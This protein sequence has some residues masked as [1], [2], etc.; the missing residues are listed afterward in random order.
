MKRLELLSKVDMPALQGNLLK[1]RQRALVRNDLPKSA[2][3]AARIFGA[4][5]QGNFGSESQRQPK[6]ASGRH[7]PRSGRHSER[8]LESKEVASVSRSG[9]SVKTPSKFKEP[10]RNLARPQL[11]PNA[12]KRSTDTMPRATPKSSRSGARR[13][14]TAIDNEEDADDEDTFH[15][16]SETLAEIRVGASYQAVIPELVCAS[17]ERNDKLLWNPS[18]LEGASSKRVDEFLMQAMPV[19]G[20]PEDASRAF[21]LGGVAQAMPT[22]ISAQ[23]ECVSPDSPAETPAYCSSEYQHI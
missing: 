6:R 3:M 1:I 20:V 14:R 18:M 12:R 16:P 2:A 17:E 21:L 10:V 11:S 23:E 5:S 8:K 9:R 15:G 22:H 7:R 4:P 13:Q 19:L